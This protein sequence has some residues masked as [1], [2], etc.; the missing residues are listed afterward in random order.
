MANLGTQNDDWLG[1]GARPSPFVPESAPPLV[2]DLDSHVV[3]NTK[4]AITQSVLQLSALSKEACS[5]EAFFE[6]FLPGVCDAMGALAACVWR[7]DRAKDTWHLIARTSDAWPQWK[8]LLEEAVPTQLHRRLLDCIHEERQAVVVPPAHVAVDGNRPCNPTQHL[9]L[10]APAPVSVPQG[11]YWLQVVQTAQGGPATQRGFLRFVAQ[12]AEYLADHLKLARLR[13][14]EQDQAYIAASESLLIRI[15][16]ARPLEEHLRD[17]IDT[18]AALA[19]ADQVFLAVRKGPRSTWRI[20]HASGLKTI[21]RHSDGIRVVGEAIQ[22]ACG[23]ET[24]FEEPQEI[25]PS[26]PEGIQRFQ[27]LFGSSYALWIPLDGSR[28]GSTV[29]CWLHW[30]DSP[31]P[32]FAFARWKALAR[33]GLSAIRP[34]WWRKVVLEERG[35]RHP[36]EKV[37]AVSIKAKIAFASLMVIGIG[38]FPVPFHVDAPARLHPVSVQRL[39]APSHGV[40]SHIGFDYGQHVEAGQVVLSIEDRQLHAQLEEAIGAQSKNEERMRELENRLRRSTT[41]DALA[42]RD[43]IEAEKRTL[44]QAIQSQH[45]RIELLQDFKKRLDLRA[46]TA[47]QVATWDAIQHLRGRP[48]KEGQLLLSLVDTTQGWIVEAEIDERD[49]GPIQPIANAGGTAEVVLS[50]D[51]LHT[52]NGSIVSI[53]EQVTRGASAES[54]TFVRMKIALPPESTVQGR[55]GTTARVR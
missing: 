49:L 28:K 39:Y 19:K 10:F 7:R 1:A 20:V 21:D 46:D 5:S 2:R 51:P 44:A 40:V 47:S 23:E 37:Q 45:R 30:V 24:R 14:L 32:S 38:A 54:S 48:V 8:S 12:A 27:K 4:A 15:S 36:W 9:L 31:K 25:V 42:Q 53:D 3:R 52:L 34:T 22:E 18:L 26:A 16:H 13:E 6:R 43:Q 29:G 55:E 17:W 33:V 41:N 11:E 50:H 35:V